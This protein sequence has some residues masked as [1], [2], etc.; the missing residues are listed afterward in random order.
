MP[1]LLFIAPPDPVEAMLATGAL[2]FA[3]AN[4]PGAALTVVCAPEAAPWF[5]A[6]PNLAAMHALERRAG[7]GAWINLALKHA[8]HPFDLALD[9]SGAPGG[10]AVHARRRIVRRTP[11]VLMHRA[12]EY[13]ALLCAD[14]PLGPVIWLDA[15]AREAAASIEGQAL[16]VLA[17]DA[18]AAHGWPGDN[19]AAVARRLAGG[20]LAEA[21]VVVL[22]DAAL[23][24]PIV[25]SL[26]ADGVAALDLGGGL[27]ALAAAA[28][29]ERAVFVLGTDAPLAH[30]AAALNAPTLALYGATDERV[31]APHGK[32]VKTMRAHEFEAAVGLGAS[33]KS[34]LE[35]LT[36]DQVEAAALDLLRAGGLR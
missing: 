4:Q 10:Y 16:L 26:D 19:Y 17:P 7:L 3:L 29:M 35:A 5:R 18:R 2:N 25:S 36:V 6:A 34:L 28:L 21:R 9:L 30:A 22:G 23:T 32:R 31:R 27:D 11:R 8:R 24:G 20:P 14:A 33:E 1:S 12:E 13:A 15:A